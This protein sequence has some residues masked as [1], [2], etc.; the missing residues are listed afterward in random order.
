[1]SWRIYLVTTV[2]S[3]VLIVALGVAW[4]PRPHPGPY[5]IG[6]LVTAPLSV[7]G[8]GVDGAK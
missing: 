3:I 2:V 1:M 5:R 8:A 7:G 6:E 4:H